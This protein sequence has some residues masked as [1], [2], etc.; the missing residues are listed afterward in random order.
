MK[1]AD[2]SFVGKLAIPNRSNPIY[3]YTLAQSVLTRRYCRRYGW[4]GEVAFK[5]RR[6]DKPS[7][8]FFSY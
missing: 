1:A 4:L 7:G 6:T 3:E 8:N 5:M 2:S